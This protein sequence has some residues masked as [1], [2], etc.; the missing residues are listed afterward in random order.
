[1]KIFAL[2][3]TQRRDKT[4]NIPGRNWRYFAQ[5]LANTER[6]TVVA[7]GNSERLEKWQG[8]DPFRV[9]R[10]EWAPLFVKVPLAA[11]EVE[12]PSNP[13]LDVLGLLVKVPLPA[14][15]ESSKYVTPAPAP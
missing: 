1:M 14:L 8:T 15:E 7:L 13:T 4:R 2:A 3:R 10:E 9:A 6:K 5:L 12:P 11:V